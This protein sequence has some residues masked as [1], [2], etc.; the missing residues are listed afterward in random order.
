MKQQMLE[1][2]VKELKGR[3]AALKADRDIQYYAR[4]R[5][6]H[7]FDK[8]CKE[9]NEYYTR[10]KDAEADNARLLDVIVGLLSEVINDRCITQSAAVEKARATINARKETK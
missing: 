5:A 2:E 1:A 9:T 4:R 8:K 6:M 10:A 7:E 3:I